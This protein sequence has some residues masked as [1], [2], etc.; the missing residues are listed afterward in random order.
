MSDYRKGVSIPIIASINCH[1]VRDWTKFA[2]NLENAGADAIELN[3]MLINTEREYK[4]GKVEQTNI[5]I[6][7][8]VKKQVK[9]PVI[10]KIG[11]EFTNLISLLNKFE[12]NKAS[13]IVMFNKNY[14]NEVDHEGVNLI[15]GAKLSDNGLFNQNLRWLTIAS[16]ILPSLDIAFSGAVYNGENIVKAILAG[17]K[18]TQICSTIYKNGP[19]FIPHMLAYLTDW[20][21]MHNYETIDQFRGILNSPIIEDENLYQRIQFMK[22][23]SNYEKETT[24]SDKEL[25]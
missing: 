25:L 10:M 13:G 19:D 5:E 18:V 3:V 16:S 20:M 22:H 7:K 4:Y 6:L 17:A 9:I 14:S 12:S 21:Q 2:K 24:K 23:F 8:Q 11:R 1:T 15:P